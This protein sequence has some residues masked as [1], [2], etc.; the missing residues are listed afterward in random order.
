MVFTI[1]VSCKKKKKK[2]KKVKD[3]SLVKLLASEFTPLVH[4]PAASGALH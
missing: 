2:E 3:K 1:L 4:S